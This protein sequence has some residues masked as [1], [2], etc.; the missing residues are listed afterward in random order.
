MVAVAR[1]A[2]RHVKVVLSGD[3]ADEILAG[4]EIYRADRIMS[5]LSRVPTWVRSTAAQAVRRHVAEET[6]RKTTWRFKV[7]QFARGLPREPQSAHG[8]WRILHTEDEIIPHVGIEHAEEIRQHPPSRIFQRHYRD[9]PDLDLLDQHLYVD[10]KTWL[11][12]DVLVKV[13]RACMASS[14]E[15]RA[16]FLAREV[17]EVAAGLPVHLKLGAFRGK[18]A[19]RR[20]AKSMLPVQTLR[21]RKSGFSAPVNAWFQWGDDN[22]YRRFNRAVR[23]WQTGGAT[24]VAPTN[25]ARA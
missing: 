8:E 15:A 18:I 11:V 3:G 20:V 6:S 22:E 1:E 2:A 7:R 25:G 17:V 10:A 21:K 5:W 14:L 13:D 12:D 23:E 19:L 24:T 4:Y 16:P 9:V